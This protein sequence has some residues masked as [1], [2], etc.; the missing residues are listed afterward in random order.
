MRMRAGR[1]H[2]TIKV[3]R[4]EVWRLIERAENVGS[5]W[6]R[7]ITPIQGEGIIEQGS[8]WDTPRSASGP[9]LRTE[10]DEV[11]QERKIV[12]HFLLPRGK[13]PAQIWTIK[14]EDA[15]RHG[16]KASLKQELDWEMLYRYS[17]GSA[18]IL[19][20]WLTIPLTGLYFIGFTISSY[21]RTYVYPFTRFSDLRKLKRV[22]ESQPR[23]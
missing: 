16:C 13:R 6:P 12:F 18:G 23:S 11:L 3:P 22:V 9:P 15:G 21:L 14:L 4:G 17:Y 1:Q 5:W 10:V 20:L 2:I 8:V 19:V 7:E